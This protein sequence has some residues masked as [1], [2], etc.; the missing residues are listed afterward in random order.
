[1]SQDQWAQCIFLD[2]MCQLFFLGGSD[3][4]LTESTGTEVEMSQEMLD[5]HGRRCC[6]D[7]DVYQ[8]FH[9]GYDRNAMG[10][11]GDLIQPTV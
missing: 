1:M 3:L 7:R 9:R 8:K 6:N 10:V 4:D 11:Y 5:H 2:S